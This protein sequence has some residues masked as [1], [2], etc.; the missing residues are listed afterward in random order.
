MVGDGCLLS[1]GCGAGPH[2][3]Y[4]VLDK[5]APGYYHRLELDG[6]ICGSA[7]GAN[8]APEHAMMERLVVDDLL[9]WARQYRV[10]AP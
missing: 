3:R 5:I 2:S 8:N 6:S 10:G 1:C 4:S 7:F 9:H